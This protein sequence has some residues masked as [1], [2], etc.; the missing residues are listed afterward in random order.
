MQRTEFP[1]APQG[2]SPAQFVDSLN[3][4][5]GNSLTQAERDALVAGLSANN[6]PT[7]RANAV[8][9]VAEN[10]ELSRREFNK[11]FVLMQYMGYMR[12]DPDA[13][14]DE[15]FRGFQ[16]WLTKPR[17]QTK[18]LQAPMGEAFIPQSSTAAI[19][20]AVKGRACAS[21]Q[22]RSV[23]RGSVLMTSTARY[24]SRT[25]LHVTA[26]GSTVSKVGRWLA[27]VPCPFH[28]ENISFHS[29][30]ATLARAS[31]KDAFGR[32]RLL[33]QGIILTAPARGPVCASRPCCSRARRAY[34][35]PR[36]RRGR[37]A[38]RSLLARPSNSPTVWTSACALARPAR[39]VI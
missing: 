29:P 10:A 39:A 35:S 11:A 18:P 36:R 12:R 23:A 17:V 14:P 5:T 9:S 6:N 27:H 8:R 2:M 1:R 25:V 19:R 24:R 4:N 15:D 20:P 32:S 3:A 33:T 16:F 37:R 28:E 30:G 38:A 13:L 22:Y 34:G 31:L 7:G 26:P 21:K